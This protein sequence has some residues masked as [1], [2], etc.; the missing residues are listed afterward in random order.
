MEP[1]ANNH[2]RTRTSRLKG[3]WHCWLCSAG[4]MQ[5]IKRKTMIATHRR[6]SPA[7]R[8][9]PASGSLMHIRSSISRNR[10]RRRWHW[11]SIASHGRYGLSPAFITSRRRILRMAIFTHGTIMGRIGAMTLMIVWVRNA[12]ASLTIHASR[13]IITFRWNASLTS[14]TS[15]TPLT[16]DTS[17]TSLTINTTR[18]HFL[19]RILPRK[20]FQSH[21]F[22]RLY[23]FSS[24]TM[25][26][27]QHWFLWFFLLL[28]VRSFGESSRFADW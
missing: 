14:N 1:L 10:R 26:A 7:T 20:A 19:K 9:T 21:V 6:R 22:T 17:V 16:S 3:T 18:I 13:R 28:I 11:R 5:W 8:W 4:I 24:Q 25:I 12:H 23:I 15:V 2:P 27:S